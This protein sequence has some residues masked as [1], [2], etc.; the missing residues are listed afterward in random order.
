M[1]KLFLIGCMCALC[2]LLFGCAQQNEDE[3]QL[4]EMKAS[5]IV[6]FLFNLGY[7]VSGA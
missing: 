5:E 7:P 1:K 2:I 3:I 4:D 6:S